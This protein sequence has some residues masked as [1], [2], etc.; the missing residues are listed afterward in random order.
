M[1][2]EEALL[3]GAG[4]IIIIALLALYM[5]PRVGV[6]IGGVRVNEVSYA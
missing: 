5:M 4:G 2:T 6:S 3:I 1:K